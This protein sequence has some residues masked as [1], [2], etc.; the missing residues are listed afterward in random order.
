MKIE[1]TM[2]L[3]KTGRA[4]V[5]RRQSNVSTVSG[6]QPRLS[7]LSLQEDTENDNA[8]KIYTDPKVDT[9]QQKVSYY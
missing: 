1:H 4:G 3:N 7:T 2:E 5:V 9:I 6:R 8:E